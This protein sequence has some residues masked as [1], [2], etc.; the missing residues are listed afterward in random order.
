MLRIQPFNT[1]HVDSAV[2]A[3]T[4]IF[5]MS[6]IPYI[7]DFQNSGCSYVCLD[8]HNIVQ[9]FALVRR[10]VALHVPKYELGWLMVMPRY[11]KNGYASRLIDMVKSVVGF[12]GLTLSVKTSNAV[13]SNLYL[14]AGFERLADPI[15]FDWIPEYKCHH[16]QKPLSKNEAIKE[17]IVTDVTIGPYGIMNKYSEETVCYNCRTRVES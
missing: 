17:Q 3:F 4:E 6:E 15:Y 1:S 2:R 5:H 16:C 12:S 14:K 13:A 7:E 10:I 9:G 11:R 8:R